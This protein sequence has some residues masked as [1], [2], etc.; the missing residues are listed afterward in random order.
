VSAALTE[1]NTTEN[2]AMYNNINSPSQDV[3]VLQPK[4]FLT[5]TNQILAIKT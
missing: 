3:T 1:K 5:A 4:V 2:S